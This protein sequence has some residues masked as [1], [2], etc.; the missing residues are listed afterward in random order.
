M[1]DLE[2]A[3][4]A[5]QRE[6]SLMLPG[7]PGGDLKDDAKRCEAS[8]PG[9]ELTFVVMAGEDQPSYLAKPAPKAADS[10]TAKDAA[11][12]PPAPFESSEKSV[13]KQQDGEESAPANRPVVEKSTTPSSP[14]R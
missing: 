11:T 10:P 5:S 13:K 2:A 3:Q 14:S 8:E 6:T 9:V 12:A 1:R 4:A 7:G